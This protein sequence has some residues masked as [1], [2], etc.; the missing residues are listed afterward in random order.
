MICYK[1]RHRNDESA[2]Q[3]AFTS[4][5]F[6]DS[7]NPF[8]H[9]ANDY[10]F[11]TLEAR[12]AIIDREKITSQE[13]TIVKLCTSFEI[14]EIVYHFNFG[15]IIAFFSNGR[16]VDYTGVIPEYIV[17]ELLRVKPTSLL[18]KKKNEMTLQKR[19]CD[20]VQELEESNRV[21][22]NYIPHQLAK[23]DDNP[24]H[25]SFTFCNTPPKKYLMESVKSFLAEFSDRIILLG[26]GYVMHRQLKYVFGKDYLF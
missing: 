14:D 25:H 5:G 26:I 6:D 15:K 23:Q 22:V 2:I 9:D 8:I 16:L 3:F 18:A 19:L 10:L 7:F 20:C 21:L 4:L 1:I 12:N 11:L 17:D 24:T 13:F